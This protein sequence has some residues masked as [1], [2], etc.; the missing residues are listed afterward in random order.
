MLEIIILQ[1]NFNFIVH[2]F[3]YDRNSVSVVKCQC[4]KVHLALNISSF[5]HDC[6]CV[7]NGSDAMAAI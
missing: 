7:I 6:G 2:I 3:W 1:E 4:G 5:A